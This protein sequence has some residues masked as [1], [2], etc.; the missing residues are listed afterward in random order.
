MMKMTATGD[1]ILI[2]GYPE[3]GYP[4]LSEIQDYIAK[5][6]ARF[7]NLETCITF[8]DTYASA[9]SGGTWMNAE[10]RVLPK[11]LNY[12]FNF[13]GFANN[14]TMDMGPDGLLETLSFVRQYDVSLAGAGEDLKEASRAAVRNTP[15]GRVAFLSVSATFNPAAA[16][17]D[18]SA[19]RKGRPGLHFLRKKTK[20]FVSKMHF[21]ALKE[22]AEAAKIP[23]FKCLSEDRILLEQTEI[24][25]S[26]DGREEK[27]TSC[28][29]EDL[30]RI[31][32]TIRNAKAQADYVV[33]MLHDHA[34]KADDMAEPDDAA[35]EFAHFCIDRGAHALIGTGTHQ[36]K[37]IEIYKGRPV[38]YSLG[39]FCFQSNMV[40]HQPADMF[41]KFGFSDMTDLQG[42]AA[43]SDGW[44]IGHH[45]Q[46]FNFRTVIPYMEFEGGRLVK[47]EMKPV[48]LGF[49]KPRSEK[50]I[51]Y[52][53]SET[54]GREIFARLRE[55]SAPRGTRLQM[56]PDGTISVELPKMQEE[57]TSAYGETDAKKGG[58][59]E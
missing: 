10:P 1:S 58:R 2:Q 15:G 57:K 31:G 3:D 18:G 19:G 40:E 6:D 12:G 53:A 36:F 48:E 38:F 55:L 42:L 41:D 22:V 25:V 33:V 47:L 24:E 46:F 30:E 20:L 51:P 4:G 28:V 9:Y 59:A 7:G 27:V 43:R 49:E 56:N 34:I 16:A 37:P 26:K 44:K 14:H 11:I 23:G 52:P 17:E 13:L 21:S 8:W 32:E 39:N 5:G 29:P 54:Q 35:V 50:G 45:T